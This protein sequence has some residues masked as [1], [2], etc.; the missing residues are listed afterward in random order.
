M[1]IKK[2]V[3]FGDSWMYGDELLDPELLKQD[4]NA[5]TCFYQ[6]DEYRHGHNFLGLLAKH[7]GWEFENYGIPGGSLQSEVW[8]FLWWLEREPN[9]SECLV[10]A[11]HTDQDRMSF[12]NPSHQHYT[13]DPIWNKFVHTAWTEASDDVIARDWKDFMKRYVVMCDS[14]ELGRYN[15]LQ[16]AMLFD[17]M[18][19][20]YKFPLLQFDIMPR[21][22]GIQLPTHIF[23]GQCYTIH[24]RDRPDNRN[25]ELYCENGH[26]NE[27][28][29]EII[30]D[31]LIPEIDRAILD[32]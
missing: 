3:G 21:P 7:Y 5:H 30:R 2:I 6:N 24:F 28:G 16:A 1:K 25:R 11:G 12:Y 17:G 9:P 27:H 19:L 18:S 32:M 15:Y 22:S 26:P 13:N 20:R 10:L 29:H 4:P 31:Q 8:T 23:N 14:P